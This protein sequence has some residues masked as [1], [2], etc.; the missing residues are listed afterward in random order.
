M[1]NPGGHKSLL[2]A[3]AMVFAFEGLQIGPPP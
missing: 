1:V 3:S 2:I